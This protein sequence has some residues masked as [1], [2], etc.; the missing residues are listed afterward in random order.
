MSLYYQDDAVTIHLGDCREILP[1][2]PKVDACITSPPYLH[3][4]GY[5]GITVAEL[6]ELFGNM[7]PIADWLW[8]NLGEIYAAGGNGGGGKLA[9]KRPGWDATPGWRKPPE[10][11][12]VKDQLLFPFRV[13]DAVRETG[14]YLRSTIIWDK[15]PATEP[16]RPDRP[17]QSH[18]Y[19]FLFRSSPSF[20]R[21][22][23]IELGTVWRI[24]CDRSFDHPAT[25]PL[26][27]ALR[28]ISYCGA[29]TV[30]DPF[31]G[32]GTTLRAAK[33]L[34]RKAIGIEIEEKYCEIGAKRMQQE[35]LDFGGAA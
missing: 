31:M 5:D 4:R 18:E 26:P 24:P 1:T 35:M 12:K 28:C 2:L 14:W 20:D 8:L 30:V 33:D 27:L 29:E 21:E 23:G 19:V 32:S 7:L 9:K 16:I 6:T 11:F 13:A 34:G 25:M 10:G 22:G 17:P 15:G 3:L